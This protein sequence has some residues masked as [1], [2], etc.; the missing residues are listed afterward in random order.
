MNLNT[1]KK[2]ISVANSLDSKG[3]VKESDTLDKIITKLAEG[4]G[5]YGGGLIGLEQNPGDGKFEYPVT[6][7]LKSVDAPMTRDVRENPEISDHWYKIVEESK[8]FVDDS[9]EKLSKARQRV[10]ETFQSTVNDIEGAG[11]EDYLFSQ[12]LPEEREAPDRIHEELIDA[13]N[14]FRTAKEEV[15]YADEN[16]EMLTKTVAGYV[17]HNTTTLDNELDR[18][19]GVLSADWNDPEKS[20]I[21]GLRSLDKAWHD[22]EFDRPMGRAEHRVAE[23]QGTGARL[24]KEEF[25]LNEATYRIDRAIKKMH[26]TDFADANFSDPWPGDDLIKA[27]GELELAVFNIIDGMSDINPEYG[28]ELDQDARRD[29]NEFISEME[30]GE[31]EDLIPPGLSGE[32]PELEDIR[33]LQFEQGMDRPGL[34]DVEDR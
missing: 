30:E 18:L 16:G 33:Q 13:Y 32:N 25:E 22:S 31:H 23:P 3:L 26:S 14:E 5:P 8:I 20:P 29:A 21:D 4:D 11:F 6:P 17:W 9:I 10:N 34:F 2:L 24:R 7:T 28:E 27:H 12:Q 15:D 1:L 19:K